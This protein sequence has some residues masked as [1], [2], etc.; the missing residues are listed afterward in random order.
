M[1]SAEQLSSISTL[2]IST[3]RIFISVFCFNCCEEYLALASFILSIEMHSLKV[4]LT[5]FTFN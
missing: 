5:R 3:V 4:V 2:T 1:T